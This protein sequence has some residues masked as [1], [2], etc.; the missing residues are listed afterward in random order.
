[1]VDSVILYIIYTP[2]WSLKLIHWFRIFEWIFIFNVALSVDRQ[3][4]ML[5][6]IKKHRDLMHLVQVSKTS[7]GVNFLTVTSPHGKWH[8]T[9]TS[10]TCSFDS[11]ICPAWILTGW[12][13][14]ELESVQ[15]PSWVEKSG[16]NTTGH[17][18]GHHRDYFADIWVYFLS[19][20]YSLLF[21][22]VG[23]IKWGLVFLHSLVWEWISYFTPHAT[24]HV[25]TNQCWD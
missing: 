9:D 14:I 4:F 24:R 3:L 15:G 16:L 18:G 19:G 25:F 10:I 7:I 12:S 6:K 1:M 5:M 22:S 13:R 23:G 8:H 20:V 2:L 11:V 17:P 21:H